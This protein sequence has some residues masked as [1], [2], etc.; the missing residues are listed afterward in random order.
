[1]KV[2]FL[3]LRGMLHYK[4]I[5]IWP[6]LPLRTSELTFMTEFVYGLCISLIHNV[7]KVNSLFLRCMLQYKFIRIWTLSSKVMCIS[8]THFVM[9]VNSL[10]RRAMLQYNFIRIWPLLCKKIWPLLLPLRTSELTLMT[11]LV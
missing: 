8:D 11:E 2:N 9:K 6:L 5:R 4:F 7:M 10:F 1:M 3:F